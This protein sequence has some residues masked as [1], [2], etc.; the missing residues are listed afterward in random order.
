MRDVYG[1]T[2]IDYENQ[3]K[4]GNVIYDEGICGLWAMPAEMMKKCFN[5]ECKE[6]YGSRVFLVKPIADC[7][8]LN[9]GSEIIGDRY[10]VIDSLSLE[11][12]TDMGALCNYLLEDEINNYKKEIDII[13]SEKTEIRKEIDSLYDENRCLLQSNIRLIENR[14]ILFGVGFVTGISFLHNPGA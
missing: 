13:N 5:T 3:L 14:K 6:H 7:F 11:D 1:A 10:E 8:Y 12:T 9:D 4:G 2:W